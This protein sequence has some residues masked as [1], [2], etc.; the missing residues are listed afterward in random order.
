[1]IEV[2][3]D[4]THAVGFLQTAYT[5]LLA[6]ALGEAFRQFILDRAEQNIQWNRLP[7][8]LGFLF[9]IF[10]FFHGM[11]R[12][13]FVTYLTVGTDPTHYA[14]YLMFDGIVFMCLSAFFF[15][16]S[17][18]LSSGHWRQYYCFLLLLL[19]V[20]SIWVSVAIWRGIQLKPWLI[21]NVAL[22]AVLLIVFG[23]F[24]KKHDSLGPP[25]I[26][27][28]TIFVTTLIS[29]IKMSHFYFP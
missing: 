10:P 11:S 19:F 24:R 18:S 27:A 8:L 29:Y 25:I 26:C 23:L 20:D 21:L 7:A 12:Y 14:A 28:T 16:M 22:A 15:G 5:I 9:L 13:F 6:L 3:R 17:R 1:M 4:I 2:S